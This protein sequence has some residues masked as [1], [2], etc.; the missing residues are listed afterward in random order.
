MSSILYVGSGDDEIVEHA[1]WVEASSLFKADGNVSQE[2]LARAIALD[3]SLSQSRARELAQ[4]AF[5]ELADRIESCGENSHP[6]VS[7]YPFELVDGNTMLQKKST[8][9]SAPDAGLLYLFLLALTRSDMSSKAR[10]RAKLDPTKIFERLCADVLKEF[11]GGESAHSDCI[12]FGT[13]KLSVKSKGKAKPKGARSNVFSHHVNHLCSVLQEGIGWR[14]NAR[15]PGAGDGKLDVV[16][17]RRFRDRRSGSLV[18][19]AQCKTGIHWREHLPK[20]QPRGFCGNYMVSP[21]L[22][23]PMRIYMVPH[24]IVANRWDEDTRAGGLLFDRCRIAHYGNSIKSE[25]LA[26]CRKW[27]DDVIAKAKT[28]P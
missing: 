7:C 6:R 13:A 2:D 8:D 28:S 20:L 22:V 5:D 15:S 4:D 16:V 26:D 18:G 17:Y 27:L 12:V 25:T 11:W 10:K 9:A 19:F 14:T 24:R 3:R 1:D 21:L 23:D